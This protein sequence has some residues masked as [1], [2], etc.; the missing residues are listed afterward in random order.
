M[1]TF[2]ACVP[3]ILTFPSCFFARGIVNRLGCGG[4]MFARFNLMGIQRE[5]AGASKAMWAV[6]RFGLVGVPQK[7]RIGGK[8]SACW[9]RRA[10]CA[11]NSFS[12]PAAVAS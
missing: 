3:C 11:G 1:Q 10:E 12:L 5:G 7:G 2:M 8:F 6:N 4:C 9:R